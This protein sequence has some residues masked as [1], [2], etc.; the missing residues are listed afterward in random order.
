MDIKKIV[1]L[2]IDVETHMLNYDLEITKL[3]RL[4]SIDN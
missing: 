4:L 3:L 1:G 2:T